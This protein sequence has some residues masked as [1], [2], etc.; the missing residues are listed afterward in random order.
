MLVNVTDEKNGTYAIRLHMF[1][2]VLLILF[3]YIFFF[4]SPETQKK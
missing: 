1:E 3:H 4:F 2:C